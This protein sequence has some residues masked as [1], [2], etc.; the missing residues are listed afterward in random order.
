M[1][2][3]ITDNEFIYYFQENCTENLA[4][5]INYSIKEIGF[6]SIFKSAYIKHKG[7]IP[8]EKLLKFCPIFDMKD[9][10]EFHA[11]ICK[12]CQI[13]RGFFVQER[14]DKVIKEIIEKSNKSKASITARWNK[15]KALKGGTNEHT[16]VSTNDYTKDKDKDKVKDKDIIIN[17]N[18][19]KIDKKGIEIPDFIDSELWNEFLKIRNKSK[20]AVNSELAIKKLINKINKF[21]EK[22]LSVNEILESSVLAGWTDIYEPKNNN[23]NKSRLGW[24]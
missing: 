16:N 19:E 7:K 15:G 14:F 4:L 3:K 10:V 18:I 8:T 11:F 12:F 22:G 24:K 9:A 17:N 2:K 6:I 13:K 23:N 5:Q 1:S 21:H 20:K